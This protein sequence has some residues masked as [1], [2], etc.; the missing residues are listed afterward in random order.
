MALHALC[1]WLP[2]ALYKF[3]LVPICM[4]GHVG[5]AGLFE[6]QCCER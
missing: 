4:C 5:H 6:L 2:F 3:P 1:C